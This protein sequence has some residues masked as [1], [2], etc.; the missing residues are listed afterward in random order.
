MPTPPAPT[1]QL[2]ARSGVPPWLILSCSEGKKLAAIPHSVLADWFNSSVPRALPELPSSTPVSSAP[3]SSS[4]R[5]GA[6]LCVSGASVQLNP[7]LQL[8]VTLFPSVCWCGRVPHLH[9]VGFISHGPHLP[10]VPCLPARLVAVILVVFSE[11]RS[12]SCS[13]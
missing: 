9:A 4:R 10:R 3:T 5:L 8:F 12:G 13:A 1:R 7:T 2:R 11:T 6:V